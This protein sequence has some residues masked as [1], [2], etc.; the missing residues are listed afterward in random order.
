MRAAGSFVVAWLLGLALSADFAMQN[1][2]SGNVGFALQN[3]LG[4]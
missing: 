1:R 2:L 3:L 4:R